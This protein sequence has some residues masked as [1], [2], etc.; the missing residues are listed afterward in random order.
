MVFYEILKGNISNDQ[1]E[2][3]N[4]ARNLDEIE[5]LKKLS[6]VDENYTN[7]YEVIMS[8]IK[9]SKKPL[10]LR[11]KADR[12][13]ETGKTIQRTGSEIIAYSIKSG[14]SR[15]KSKSMSKKGFSHF[16]KEKKSK[17]VIEEE[18]PVRSRKDIYT[19]HCYH[20]PKEE[21]TVI[22]NENKLASLYS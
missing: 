19:K 13:I 7:D 18:K 11:E 14:K 6:G 16:D 12:L 8:R 1:M 20:K 5:Y 4:K 9:N 3:F 22:L 17:I 2:E 21:Y 10:T 15:S